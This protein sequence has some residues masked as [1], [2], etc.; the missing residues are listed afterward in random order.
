ML[1]RAP[2]SSSKGCQFESRQKR[3]QNF[4]LHSQLCVLT[5]IPCPFRSTPVLPQWHVKDPCHSAKS[6]GGRLHLNTYTPLTQ[7]SQSG[8]TMLSRR[9]VGTYWENEFVHNSSGNTR[10]QSSQLAEPMWTDPGLEKWNWCT[11]AD[12]HLNKKT[13]K[14]QAGNESLNVPSKSSQARK[15]PLTPPICGHICAWAP[16]C[17]GTTVRGHIDVYPPY[18]WDKH[19]QNVQLVPCKISRLQ[20]THAQQRKKVLSELLQTAS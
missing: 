12:L 6:A 2:D 18:R 10:P 19:E 7:R 17:V 3:R 5:L 20:T 8:L 9:S 4:L 14:A 1:V 16:R 13:K 15:K 11:R